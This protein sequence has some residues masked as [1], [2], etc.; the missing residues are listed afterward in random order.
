MLYIIVSDNVMR[1]VKN[2]HLNR[3]FYKNIPEEM[4]IE[5]AAMELFRLDSSGNDMQRMYVK[6]CPKISVSDDQLLDA[7]VEDL[8]IAILYREP[9]IPK[10]VNTF[11]EKL[12][13][14][15]KFREL[16]GFSR[17][18]VDIILTMI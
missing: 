9:K 8:A 7:L 6:N 4:L 12:A 15:D 1:N 13:K 11:E 17:K 14:Y 18:Q 16:I 3:T 10:Y 2:R 5:N